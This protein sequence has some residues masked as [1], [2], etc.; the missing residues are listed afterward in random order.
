[1]KSFPKLQTIKNYLNL[2]R[3]DK[4]IGIFLLFL[5][6]LCGLAFSS[7]NK[8]IDWI[9]FISL[10]LIGSFLMRSAGCII[11]DLF[12]KDFDKKVERTKN[13]PIASGRVSVQ[14]ALIFLAILLF[15][16]FLILL[17]FNKQ[18]II[19]GLVS[20]VFVTAYPLMKRITY[21]PQVFLGITFNLGI[22][23]ASTAIVG[24]IT[25]ITLLLYLA[26]IIWT[27]IYDTIYGYQD[28]DDDLKIG[29][30]STAIK[31]GKNP[32]KILYSLTFAYFILLVLFGFFAD[33]KFVY[34]IIIFLA[35]TILV[36][37]IKTCNFSS[38]Q[39]CLQKFKSNVWVGFV[40]FLA[41]I[42]G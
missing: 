26:N 29:I 28:L 24:K 42:F 31:F 33:F 8:N 13:R 38:H 18:T 20:V 3:F 34:F 35:A 41:I 6:C 9:Y 27:I 17:Q 16:A 22:L 32:Q 23:F 10:F 19:L 1:M 14:S 40:V 25:S 2:L 21:Y 15:F 30:K 7:K 11:N 12:D 5:P 39:N 36:C 37:Q 4:P